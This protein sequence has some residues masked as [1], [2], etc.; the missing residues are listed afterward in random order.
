MDQLTQR[1]ISNIDKKREQIAILF[2]MLYWVLGYK[3]YSLFVK[4]LYNYCR[5]EMHT[6]LVKKK[7]INKPED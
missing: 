6:F 1:N 5:P 4:S 7:N 3:R 2:K